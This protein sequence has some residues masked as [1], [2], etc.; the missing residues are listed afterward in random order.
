LKLIIETL[1]GQS[2]LVRSF[3]QDWNVLAVRNDLMIL[4]LGTITD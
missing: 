3:L 4:R 2:G 1:K